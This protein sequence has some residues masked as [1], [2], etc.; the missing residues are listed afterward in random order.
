M[1]ILRSIFYPLKAVRRFGTN[2]SKDRKGTAALEFAIVAP[3]LLALLFAILY[4]MMIY[5]AQ[6]MLETAAQSAGRLLLT[7][8]AQTTQMANGHMGMTSDDFKDAIC[9]GYSGTNSSGQAVSVPSLL[10][11][12]LT[13]SRLTVNVATATSYNVGST[14]APTF[15]YDSNGVLTST[16]TGYIYQSGGSGKNRIVVLQLVYLWPTGKGPLGLNLINQPNANRKLVAT[17]VFT[18]EDY[19]CNASQSSC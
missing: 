8:S 13:C 19:S 11:A 6:Q 16:G 7:G 2:L 17:S 12:M 9:N 10:P 4:T 5:L 1:A 14:S 3:A 15:T 18:T